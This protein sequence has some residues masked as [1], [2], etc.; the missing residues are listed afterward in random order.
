MTNHP[1][2]RRMVGYLLVR[3]GVHQVAYAKALEQLTGVEVAKMLN[4]PNIP[5]SKFPETR[6][7]EEKGLRRTLYRFSPEDYRDIDKVW[8]GSHPEDGEELRVADAPP[9]GAAKPEQPETPE[10]FVPGYDPGELA[11]IAS[12][13]MRGGNGGRAAAQGGREARLASA[14]PDRCLALAL[15][16]TVGELL[17]GLGA[18]SV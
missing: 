14:R 4:I 11:E 17:D 8:V 10:T 3:G 1:I 18:E 5:N 16:P 13:M 2:A 15:V 12:R 6:E 7:H 9:E